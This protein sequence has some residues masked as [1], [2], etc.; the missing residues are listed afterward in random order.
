MTIAILILEGLIGTKTGPSFAFSLFELQFMA[1][2]VFKSLA[3]Q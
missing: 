3:S 1:L 2:G